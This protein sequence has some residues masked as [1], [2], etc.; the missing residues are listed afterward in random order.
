[1]TRSELK[2]AIKAVVPSV[3]FLEA[4]G[5][6]TR[7]PRYRLECRVPTEHLSALTEFATSIGKSA[8]GIAV[9]CYPGYSYRCI[10]VK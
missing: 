4:D 2:R 3:Q 9:L 8:Y 5:L 1:M 6:G 10:N 7:T